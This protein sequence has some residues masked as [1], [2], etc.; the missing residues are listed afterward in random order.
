MIPLAAATGISGPGASVVIFSM[1]GPGTCFSAGSAIGFAMLF[2]D[3]FLGP[4][5]RGPEAGM[6]LAEILAQISARLSHG[7]AVEQ[8]RVIGSGALVPTLPLF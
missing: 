8:R 5:R 2:G 7:R 3:L 6:L 4:Y 1:T